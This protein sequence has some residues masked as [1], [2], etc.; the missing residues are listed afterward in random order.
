MRAEHDDDSTEEIEATPEMLEVGEVV[1][2]EEVGG[3]DDLGP[4][5]LAAD[6]A[7][8]VYL[9]MEKERRRT[10]AKLARN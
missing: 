9:A 5:F 6:L 4:L 2:M 1:I 8:K 7:R 10:L 3:A